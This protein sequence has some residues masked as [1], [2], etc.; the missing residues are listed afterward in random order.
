[1]ARGLSSLGPARLPLVRT[2]FSWENRG[3][4]ATPPITTEGTPDAA[5]TPEGMTVPTAA[6]PVVVPRTMPWRRAMMLLGGTILA[7]LLLHMSTLRSM[8]LVWTFNESFSHCWFVAPLAAYMVWTRRA[9]LVTASPRPSLWGVLLVLLS[10]GGWFLSHL[11]QVGTGEQVSLMGMILG[12]IWAIL[13]TDFCRRIAYPLAF[14][15]LMVP[16]GEG[17]FP[18]LIS[19]AGRLA[20]MVLEW[21]GMPVTFDGRFLRVPGGEWTITEACSGLRYLLT[22]LT[23]GAVYAYVNYRRPLKR[24]LFLVLCAVAAL[25]T[26]GIRVWVL[27]IV[28]A[29]TDMKSPL[30][31][32][33]AWLGWVLFAMM[34]SVIFLV[35]RRMADE[36][37]LPEDAA[38][39]A[40]DRGVSPPAGAFVAVALSVIV[41]GTAWSAL[42]RGF[43]RPTPGEVRYAGPE[44]NPGWQETTY[45]PWDWKPSYQGT[46]AEF[47]RSYEKVGEVVG[48]YVGYYRDQ[49]PGAELIQTWNGFLD[50][51]LEGWKRSTLIH[52]TVLL[53]NNTVPVTQVDL[54]APG[55]R[56]RVWRVYWVGG[57]LLASE[58]QVKLEQLRTKLAGKGDDGAVV[59]IYAG[60]ESDGDEATDRLTRFLADR[61]ESIERSLWYTSGRG[62]AKPPAG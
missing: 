49:K 7:I 34:L 17:L 28:G 61:L 46:S 5:P 30:V 31:H 42:A 3:P 4:L 25:V 32:D 29:L 57:R 56:L 62:P 26:N 47:Q 41:I 52:K 12:T 2:P 21:T 13:G 22:I 8:A 40:T 39:T 16:F 14:L 60:F 10:G 55:T 44:T 33:H 36:P 9:E 11:A 54:D 35:G 20:V 51:T 53:P 48:L 1:M 43:D 18:A 45:L 38:P 15:A 37:S 24:V 6:V 59:M 23:V 50:P 19:L 27:V 58:N